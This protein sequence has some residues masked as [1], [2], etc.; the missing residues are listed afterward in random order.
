MID[1]KT[2]RQVVIN[3]ALLPCTPG[4][5]VTREAS[6]SGSSDRAVFSCN[7]IK[8][9]ESLIF[10]LEP[11][12]EGSGDP[13]PDN[14]RPISGESEIKFFTRYGD[15]SSY[16]IPL[17]VTVYGGYYN[18]KTGELWKTHEG[19]DLSTLTW[20]YH[21]VSGQYSEF[22]DCYLPNDS[23]VGDAQ[24]AFDGYCSIYK[25]IPSRYIATSEYDNNVMALAT[26]SRRFIVCDQRFHSKNDF[27][28]GIE[29]LVLVYPLA[30]P[31]KIAT[32][33]PI[34]I[35]TNKG[36][37]EMWTRGDIPFTLEY[38]YMQGGS[39]ELAKQFLPIFYPNGK[40]V[41]HHGSTF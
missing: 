9:L 4:A 25:S 14:P 7:L 38:K 26:N 24:V 41:K 30:T 28:E 16:T 34:V 37:N 1:N 32:I 36:T 10:T 12:Q 40:G 8:P 6:G 21:T 2:I 22:F 18:S 15:P 23:I 5:E 35:N 27:V 33:D 19:V 29:G 17:T 13:S 39:C 31:V 3:K 11:Q 20:N